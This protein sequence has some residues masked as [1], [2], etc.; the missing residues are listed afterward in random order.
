MAAN[1]VVTV[2]V[3]DVASAAV[4]VVEGCE[5]A[6]VAAR[7]VGAV[8]EQRVD[9]GR[10]AVGGGEAQWVTAEQFVG[11]VDG[12]VGGDELIDDLEALMVGGHDQCT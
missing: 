3:D 12:G 2:R 5:P 4:A 7:R 8:G 1:F 9:A 6:I 10:S 11:V